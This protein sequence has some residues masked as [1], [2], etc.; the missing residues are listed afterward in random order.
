MM[1]VPPV[2]KQEGGGVTQD[3]DQGDEEEDERIQIDLTEDKMTVVSYYFI[4]SFIFVNFDLPFPTN[5]KYRYLRYQKT[6]AIVLIMA[7]EYIRST[8]Q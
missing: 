5:F 3:C 1:H 6:S 2:Q 8:M 4:V 7:K